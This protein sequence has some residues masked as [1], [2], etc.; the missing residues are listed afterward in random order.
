MKSR[1][2]ASAAKNRGLLPAMSA[3]SAKD[4]FTRVLAIISTIV[5]IIAITI[6]GYFACKQYGLSEKVYD[7][8][9][10]VF[11]QSQENLELYAMLDQNAPIHLEPPRKAEVAGVPNAT[12]QILPKIT[13]R[14]KALLSNRSLVTV[15]I[16]SYQVSCETRNGMWSIQFPKPLFTPDGAR[17]KAGTSI[18][19]GKSLSL[20]IQITCEISPN[21][22]ELLKAKPMQSLSD[23][24]DILTNHYTNFFGQAPKIQKMP[25]GM[26]VLSFTAKGYPLV[27]VNIY[28]ARDK[29]FSWD[30]PWNG[31][32]IF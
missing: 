29:E 7:L 5:S 14:Y 27:N 11:A 19:A 15:S 10:K 3:A 32:D 17:I 4:R 31:N 26:Q 13:V 20:F 2:P 18:D 1:G 23:A 25:D 6:S 16:K 22:F 12:M 30:I 24:D 28:T 9:E 21:A 8:Q